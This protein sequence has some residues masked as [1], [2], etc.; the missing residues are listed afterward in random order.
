MYQSGVP[1]VLL[2]R[3]FGK[4]LLDTLSGITG[5]GVKIASAIA[6]WVEEQSDLYPN[7]RGYIIDVGKALTAIW[8]TSRTRKAMITTIEKFFGDYERLGAWTLSTIQPL[9]PVLNFL[10][11]GAEFTQEPLLKFSL[12]L[13]VSLSLSLSVCVSFICC[14]LV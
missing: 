5:E 8:S 12:S 4:V 7:N 9:S 10:P 2:G 1:F 3:D 14:N 6:Q 11:S 13:S